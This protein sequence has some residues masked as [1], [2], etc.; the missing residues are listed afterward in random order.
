MNSLNEVQGPATLELGEVEYRIRYIINTLY[1]CCFVGPIVVIPLKPFGYQ[2]KLGLPSIERPFSLAAELPDNLFF[3]WIAEQLR[4]ASLHT[5][6]HYSIQLHLI[7][8]FPFGGKPNVFKINMPRVAEGVNAKSVA[9]TIPPYIKQETT[10]KPPKPIIIHN[11]GKPTEGTTASES[12][13]FG[14]EEE[15]ARLTTIN[16]NINYYIYEEVDTGGE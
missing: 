13:W 14:T 12:D 6:K 9:Q 16:P 10:P 7:E 4:I 8:M 15:Y 11:Q 3:E 5:V 1:D 2:I